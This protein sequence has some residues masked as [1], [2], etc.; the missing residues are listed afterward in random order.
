MIWTQRS[1][2]FSHC[3]YYHGFPSFSL[4]KNSRKLDGLTNTHNASIC[5]FRKKNLPSWKTRDLK[6]SSRWSHSL[7]YSLVNMQFD[8]K[9]LQSFRARQSVPFVLVKGKAVDEMPQRD[10]TYLSLNL[11]MFFNN[12]S[13]YNKFLTSPL[14]TTLP[15]LF[16]KRSNW[17]SIMFGT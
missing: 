7:Q 15:S 14:R 3:F 16:S 4:S 6:Q 2:P 1:G 11:Y 9:V 10:F 13:C 12:A 5:N 17:W 8:S